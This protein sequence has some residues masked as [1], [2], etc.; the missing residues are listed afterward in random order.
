MRNKNVE[1]NGL[2][3]NIID[4][5]KLFSSITVVAIH[6][7]PYLNCSTF[8]RNIFDVIFFFPV[9]FFFMCIGFFGF[10]DNL[11]YNEIEQKALNQMKKYIKL[12]VIMTVVYS[13]ITIWY[14]YTN[15]YSLS[16]IIT[17]LVVGFF[18]KGEQY[19]SWHLWF[20]LSSIYS[21]VLIFFLCKL[22]VKY[23]YQLLFSIFISFLGAIITFL[24]E[25]NQELQIPF[26][27]LLAKVLGSGRLFKGG[28][29]ILFGAGIKY[30]GSKINK[31]ICV[32]LIFVFGLLSFCISTP[33]NNI[34]CFFTALCLFAIIA[35]PKHLFSER[36]SISIRK[37][38][39]YIY[40]LHMFAFFVFTLLFRSFVY[41][42]VDAFAFS[43]IISAL[44]MIVCTILNK[45][46][47]NLAHEN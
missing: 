7:K 8:L 3:Y 9:P 44:I 33:F 38:S 27:T 28:A 45:V 25:N 43:V 46:K 31:H 35:T 18:F 1:K 17:S 22:K 39:S 23:K 30:Y 32:A 37:M 24:I 12:Y 5:C 10:G 4:L 16:Q 19:Y 15:E 11:D 42:G 26:M 6:T 14:Y 20:L 41:Y 40:F 34:T 47:K 13:P 36:V 29:Y 21:F 2:C